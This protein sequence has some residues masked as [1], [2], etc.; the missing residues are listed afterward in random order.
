MKTGVTPQI[1]ALC[2]LML[3][4]TVL[5]VTVSSLLGKNKTAVD[6]K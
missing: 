1:N 6:K 5:L 2:T 4:A 3:A